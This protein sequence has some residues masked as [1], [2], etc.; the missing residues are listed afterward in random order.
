MNATSPTMNTLMLLSLEKARQILAHQGFSLAERQPY[1]SGERFLMAKS[2]LVLAGTRASDA[3]KV[4][5]KMSNLESGRKEIR[6][7]KRVRY[8]LQSL[9][10]A[11]KTITFPQEIYFYDDDTY[12][13]LVTEF[14]EQEKIFVEYTL[15]EQF[16][17]ALRAFEEQEAF[18]ATTF[19]HTRAIAPV[20]ELFNAK[21]YLEVFHVFAETLEHE[22]GNHEAT[23]TLIRAGKFL[24][25]HAAIIDRYGN[26]FTHT[27]FVPHNFRIRNNV[28]YMLDCGDSMEVHFGNKYEGW[29]RFLNYMYIHNHALERLLTGY[30]R[31]NRGEEEYLDLRL[32]RIYKVGRLLAYYARARKETKGDLHALTEIRLN[33]WNN[34]LKCLLEDTPPKEKLITTYRTERN[35]LRSPEEKERQKDFAAP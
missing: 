30:L 17:M 3:T 13:I 26:T 5:V 2:R 31:T 18:H 23:R 4:I 22:L 10:F 1:L 19:E 35:K 8:L 28:L 16:F 27:D 9:A 6:T 34:I 33:L 14:V 25:R 12:T 21:K 29:A 24:A 15:E 32:M 11:K 20:F 7:E